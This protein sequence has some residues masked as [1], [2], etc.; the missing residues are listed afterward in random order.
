MSILSPDEKVVISQLYVKLTEDGATSPLGKAME[1]F[2][3]DKIIDLL[4]ILC[5]NSDK[6]MKILEQINRL[7]EK[8]EKK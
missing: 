7:E 1:L 4:K 3:M 6:I 2:L 8:W 5:D